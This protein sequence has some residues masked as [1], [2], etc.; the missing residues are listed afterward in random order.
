MM[1]GPMS[2]QD[3]VTLIVM[4]LSTPHNNRNV[5]SFHLYISKSSRLP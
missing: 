3:K 2:H 4:S 5:K 1:D